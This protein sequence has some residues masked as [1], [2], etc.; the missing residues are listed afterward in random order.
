MPQ[1]RL[2]TAIIF[3]AVLWQVGCTAMKF[4]PDDKK[5]YTGAEIKVLPKHKLEDKKRM[6]VSLSELLAPEPNHTI[7]GQRP[8]LWLYYIAGHPKKKKGIKYWLKNKLG[9]PPVFLSDVAPGQTSNLLQTRLQ[10][11]GFFQGQ[12]DYKVKEGKRK[13]SIVYELDPAAYH[14]GAIHFPDSSD[15]LSGAIDSIADKTLIKTKQRFDLAEMQEERARIEKAVRNQGYYYFD[16]SDLSFDADSTVGDHQVELFLKIK[17]DINPKATKPYDIGKITIIPD[18]SISGKTVK[19]DSLLVNKMHYLIDPKVIMPK[20]ITRSIK[21]KIGQPYAKKAEDVTIERLVNLGIFQYV[22]VNFNEDSTSKKLDTDIHLVPN[23]RKSLRLELQA[24]SKSNNY[25]GPFLNVIY[26]NRNIFRGAELFQLTLNSGIETQLYNGQNKALNSYQ[27]GVEASL[28]VPRLIA[29]FPVDESQ[30]KFDFKTK[31]S[32]GAQTLRRVGYYDLRSLNMGFGYH[33]TRNIHHRFEIFPVDVNF[34]QLPR[35]TEQFRELLQG[36]ELLQKTFQEQ[37]ILGGRYAYFFNASVPGQ[38]LKH[39]D[40]FYFNA[41]IN[42]SG[43]LM[44][45]AQSA[46][47]KKSEAPDSANDKIAGYPYA[48]FMKTDFDFRYYLQMDKHN[49]LA[50]RLIAGV[51]FPYGKQQSLPYIYQFAIGGSSSLRA[52]RARSVRRLLRPA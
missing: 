3:V 26:Q 49:Q 40:N 5:L 47:N 35:T 7:L 37:F 48:R 38:A 14:Y 15:V 8:A 11:K 52:F 23:K 2:H 33:W 44:H 28:L 27:L 4:I 51:G 24:V 50:T 31:F 10:N 41:N 1:R 6:M 19:H 21:L 18:Y 22:N 13:A 12:V 46:V 30:S 36:N 25:V 42:L 39:R 17:K 16:E 43:N 45:L 34:L 29:F 20:P 32:L 9:E